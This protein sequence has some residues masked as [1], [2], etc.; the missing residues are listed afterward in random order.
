M[1]KD[2][3]QLHSAVEFYAQLQSIP[4][5][6]ANRDDPLFPGNSVLKVSLNVPYVAARLTR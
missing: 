6:L 4:T 1:K 2:L 5:A 3:L